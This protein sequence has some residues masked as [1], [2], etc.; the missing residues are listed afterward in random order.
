MLEGSLKITVPAFFIMLV[1][2]SFFNLN[3]DDFMLAVK[4]VLSFGYI[5]EDVNVNVLLGAIVFAGAGGMLNL[6]VSLWYRDKQVGMGHYVGRITNPIT[7]RNE[8]VAAT[9]YTFNHN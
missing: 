4:G 2:I 6:A 5:P 1:T 7:G 3:L 8:A 9:G